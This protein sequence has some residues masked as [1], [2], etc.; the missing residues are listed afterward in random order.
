MLDN[1]SDNVPKNMPI[2][3]LDDGSPSD[4]E[5]IY[6]PGL[7]IIYKK[8]E[9]LGAR[10]SIC[11]A[12]IYGFENYNSDYIFIMED[13]ILLDKNWLEKMQL[14][15]KY[16]KT[17]DEP[18]IIAGYNY[19]LFKKTRC[20][21]QKKYNNKSYYFGKFST[22]QLLMFTRIYYKKCKNDLYKNCYISNKRGADKITH[23]FCK[24]YGLL[25]CR[26]KRS[27]C[28]HIGDIST[29]MGYNSFTK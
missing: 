29:K 5:L 2:I 11:R 4:Y 14:A 17:I 12:I 16:C 9:H 22:T 1:M 25:M 26:L 10:G 18:G 13:D 20:W 3:I 6:P 15:Y 24:N 21:E 23:N 8:L 28:E 27:V 19:G 7:N